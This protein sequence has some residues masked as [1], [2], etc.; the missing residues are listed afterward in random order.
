MRLLEK[1]YGN[2]HK[3]LASYRK[4]IKQMTKIKPA[5]AAAYRRLFNFLIKCQSLEYGSQN[6]LDKPDIICMILA[7]IL[8]YLK[9]KLNG[10]FSWMRFNCLKARATSRRQFIFYH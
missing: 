5:N 9:K 8:G 1:Q 10:P 7:K 6:P 3:L 4:E 2:P